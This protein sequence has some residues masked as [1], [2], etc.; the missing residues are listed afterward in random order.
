M[1][2]LAHLQEERRRLEAL[3]S[4]NILDTEPEPAFDAIVAS[5]AAL[6]NSPIA[7]VSLVDEGR[8]W[9]KARVGLDETETPRDIAF[10]AHAIAGEG[11]LVVP[12]ARVDARFADNPLVLGPPHLASYLGVPLVDDG[13]HALGTLCVLDRVP[14]DWTPGDVAQVARLAKVACEMFRLRRKA[15]KAESLADRI[16]EL[17]EQLDAEHS[18]FR[19]VEQLGVIGG[20]ELELQTKKLRW[21]SQT[22]RIHEVPDDFEPDLESAIEFYAP[23]ARDMVRDKVD[24]ALLTGEE[25][26]IEAPLVTAK[27]NRI[28]VRA[29]GRVVVKDGF[30]H[31]LVG[32]FQDQTYAKID[33]DQRQKGALVA[34]MKAELQEAFLSG[35]SEASFHSALAGLTRVTGSPFG[36]IGEV[37]KVDGEA[38][39]RARAVACADWTPER[40]AACRAHVADFGDFP[41]LAAMAA[42]PIAAGEPIFVN[43]TARAPEARAA[44]QWRPPLTRHV[45]APIFYAGEMVALVGLANRAEPYGQA[46]LETIQ[47]LLEVIGQLVALGR[48]RKRRIESHEHLQEALATKDRALANVAAYQAALDKHAIVAIT[49]A[50]G[51]IVFVNDRFCE[52]SGYAREELLGANHRILNSGHHPKSFFVDMWRSIGKARSWQGEICNRAKDGGLY[53]VDTTIVPMLGPDGRPERFVSVRYDITHRK[54]AD[55]ILQEALSQLTSFFELSPD[56]LCI[57]DTRGT[58]LKV[59]RAARDVLGISEKDL[60]GARIDRNVHPDDMEATHEAMRALGVEGRLATVIN[61]HPTGD[62]GWRSIEWRATRVGARVYTSARDV[63]QQL[64]HEAELRQARVEAE[65]AA[66]AKSQFLAN[67]S[68]EIRTPMNGVLGMLD[69]L[70]DSGLSAHQQDLARSG[71]SAAKALLTVL[72]DVL[73]MAKIEAGEVQI[74]RLNVDV[75]LLFKDTM[76]LFEP[77]A[78]EKDIA[79]ACTIAPGVPETIRTDPTRLRQIISNLL[80]NALK[81]TERG[82]VSLDVRWEAPGRLRVAITDTGI[83]MDAATL[84]RLFQRFAQADASITRRFGGTGLGLSICKSLAQH[85]GGDVAVTSRPGEGSRFEVTIEAPACETPKPA[86]SPGPSRED[87]AGE[88]RA[89]S[90]LVAEDYPMNQKLIGL[91]LSKLGHEATIVDDGSMVLAALDR[92]SFDV[93]LMDMQMPVMDGLTATRAIRART[94]A[95]ARTPVIALTAN[96][97]EANAQACLDAGM[98]RIVTKPIQIERLVEALAQVVAAREETARQTRSA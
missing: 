71:Q 31:K 6:T 61:R 3:A 25:W 95:A 34:Q 57:A 2:I 62:G 16:T 48:E 50:R 14:R 77:L 94:D 91:I 47:P 89:L 43:V 68:H 13:G 18:L 86:Q 21:S 30:P 84:G 74:E 39:L 42:R 80:S 28:W 73:D 65:A 75:A 76:R 53:W 24:S 52:I 55:E 54:R 60:I 87:A 70:A 33:R 5:V 19:T 15:G 26:D 97:D 78:L 40:D 69:L 98:D 45:C 72:N 79:L 66:T 44:G 64:A 23:E 17:Y 93:V 27:G 9:F 11:P 38:K 20:W 22:R 29:V 51:E 82:S 10:C 8:Q 88:R 35:K 83:G 46:D 7:L 56:L 41:E 12:D 67:M 96:A 49:D 58:M 4:L 32:A 36:F 92:A 81:F 59:S 37:L 1:F 63:T 90:I 85:M